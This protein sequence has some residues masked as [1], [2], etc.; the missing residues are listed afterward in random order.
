MK[1]IIPVNIIRPNRLKDPNAEPSLDCT[2]GVFC[3]VLVSVV[4]VVLVVGFGSLVAVTVM[5]L[6]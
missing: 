2:V 5:G 6:G 1:P 3:V 4:T